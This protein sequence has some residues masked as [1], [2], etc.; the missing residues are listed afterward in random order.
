MLGTTQP[1]SDLLWPQLPSDITNLKS[2]QHGHITLVPVHC[3]LASAIKCQEL[4]SETGLHS[5]GSAAPSNGLLCFPRIL[6]P[7]NSPYSQP[8]LRCMETRASMGQALAEGVL[9]DSS[10]FHLPGTSVQGM[11]HHREAQGMAHP[12]PTSHAAMRPQRGTPGQGSQE[13]K[14]GLFPQV[15]HAE[16]QTVPLSKGSL[17]LP[18]QSEPFARTR[19]HVS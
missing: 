3:Y 17:L 12:F 9:A 14:P 18:A 7:N 1:L 5:Q 10:P 13:L 15:L 16:L 6:N 11:G 4:W 19:C 2:T 8:V